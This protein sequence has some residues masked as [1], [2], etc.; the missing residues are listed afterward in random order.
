MGEIDSHTQHQLHLISRYRLLQE[1][2]EFVSDVLV[3]EYKS[4]QRRRSAP[5]LQKASRAALRVSSRVLV[6]FDHLDQTAEYDV[7][8]T[9]ILS[10][11]SHTRLAKKSTSLP[12]KKNKK[13]QTTGWHANPPR[14]RKQE[15]QSQSGK[16]NP[17]AQDPHTNLRIS[18]RGQ[19]SS[20]QSCLL[21]YHLAH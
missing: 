17:Q 12:Q 9:S 21:S 1:P 8:R 19:Q 10:G 13:M 3:N 16:A 14:L 7:Y 6:H 18:L 4:K 20:P 11:T 2:Y 15:S 5:G